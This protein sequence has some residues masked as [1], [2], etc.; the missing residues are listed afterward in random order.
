M[1]LQISSED[2]A[3]INQRPEVLQDMEALNAQAENKE[4]PGVEVQQAQFL[5]MD[6]RVGKL[7]AHRAHLRY[8]IVDVF[9]NSFLPRLLSKILRMSNL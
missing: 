3:F 2:D 6:A 9:S 7:A 5:M 8:G 4:Q 1:F